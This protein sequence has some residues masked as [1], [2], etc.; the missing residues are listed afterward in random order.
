MGGGSGMLPH[1]VSV[2]VSKG[3]IPK[4][5]VSAVQV[6]ATG[7]EGDGHDHEKHYRLEQAVCLQDIEKLDELRREGYVLYPGATGENLTVSHLNVNALAI[8][9]V[10]E[11]PSGLKIQLTKVRTPCYVLDAI[12][13]QLKENMIGRC[14]MY[15]KVISPGPVNE[16]DIVK[17]L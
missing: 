5:P 15:A 3:G 13:P 6:Y 7:L 1:I 11:F 17:I 9:T 10:L 16:Y 8:G 12:S 2:N 14:G 4:S